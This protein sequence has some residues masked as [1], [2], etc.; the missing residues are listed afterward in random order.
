MM[1]QEVAEKVEVK[2]DIFL[3]ELVGV[4]V[5]ALLVWLLLPSMVGLF[6]KRYKLINLPTTT[7]KTSTP[8]VSTEIS[9]NITDAVEKTKDAVVGVTNIQETSNDLWS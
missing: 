2:P 3:V 4:I 1:K 9:T 6:T 8:Q 7:N 5:G